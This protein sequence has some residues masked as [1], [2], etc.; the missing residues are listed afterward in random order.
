MKIL[1]YHWKTYSNRFLEHHLKAMGH[2]VK[3]YSDDAIT[4]SEENSLPELERELKEGYDAVFSYNY[5]KIIAL[6]C[7]AKKVPY[8]AWTL[9]SPMLG[10]YDQTAYL[11][12]NYF[13]CFDYEQYEKMKNRGIRNAFYCPL[14]TDTAFVQRTAAACTES[15]ISKYKAQISFVGSLYTE[16]DMWTGLNGMPDFLKG[17]FEGIVQTQLR[18][19]S[20]RFS[21]AQIPLDVMKKIRQVLEFKG[22]DESSVRYEELIDNLIDRQVTVVEREKM[23]ALLAKNPRFKLYT[24]S[25]TTAYPNVNNCGAVDY[26]TEMPK[27]FRHS[28]INLNV[29]LRSIRSG[30][31]LRVLDVV[32][33]GGFCLTNAQAELDLF[34]K[35]GESIATFQS[36]EEMEEK[37]EYYLAHD[38]ERR[39]IIENGY[40]IVEKQFDFKVRLPQIFEL[41][42]L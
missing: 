25:D 7:H 2:E 8:I 27:V 41:A 26:Y 16:K 20:L 38:F 12:T 15:E 36:L 35:E 28:D 24:N 14:A 33:A 1:F 32:A 4:Q 34:F 11:E 3:V 10:L 29:T 23:I 9:D 30:I 22:L 31:P 39:R 42:G 37:I 5:F 13:F 17:Y 18:L 21:Q 6:A 19:P 40:K